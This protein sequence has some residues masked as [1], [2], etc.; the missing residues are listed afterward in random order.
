MLENK[1]IFFY[2]IL[3][4]ILLFCL[5]NRLY[6]E[7]ILALLLLFVADYLV[8]NF[9]KLLFQ[10]VTRGFTRVYT[11]GISGDLLLYAEKN[12]YHSVAVIECFIQEQGI[13]GKTLEKLVNSL[14]FPLEL[15]L[16][17]EELD[18]KKY[19]D[20][21]KELRSRYE[22]QKAQLE[23]TNK[24]LNYPEVSAIERK[25][26]QVNAMIERLSHGERPY[27]FRYYVIVKA[28]GRDPHESAT[29]LSHRVSSAERLFSTVFAGNVRRL[30]G[31]ELYE[32]FA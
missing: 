29:L 21:L 26:A 9:K 16:Q 8:A 11:L 30:S 23:D 3:L 1:S 5:F 14:D 10:Y 15:R 7:M 17:I 24:V 18:M 19:I 13:D 20:F 31:Y 22:N 28:D 27:R 25:I 4:G 32:V 2:L 6:F 12:S